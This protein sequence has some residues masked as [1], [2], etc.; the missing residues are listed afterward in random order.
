[1]PRPDAVTPAVRQQVL[2]RDRQCVAALLD[3]S[4]QCRDTWGEPHSPWDRARLT[5]EHVKDEPMMGKRA[6]SDPGHLVAMC[7]GGNAVEHWG[8][9][10]RGLCLAYLAGC[11][12]GERAA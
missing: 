4:H 2:D 3:R 1:M 8:S 9:A 11:I 5:I 12:A 6:P 7:H 10:N